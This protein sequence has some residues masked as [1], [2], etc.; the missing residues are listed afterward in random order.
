MALVRQW[1]L[2]SHQKKIVHGLTCMP[3]RKKETEKTTLGGGEYL[4]ITYLIRHV[5]PEQ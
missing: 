3:Q 2:K 4:E 5:H 1:F